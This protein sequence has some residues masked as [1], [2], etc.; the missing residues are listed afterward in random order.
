M[1]RVRDA[2]HVNTMLLIDDL[3]ERGIVIDAQTD[4]FVPLSTLGK[5]RASASRH[6]ALPSAKVVQR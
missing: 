3:A 2:Q 6:A 5:L 1:G 4:V